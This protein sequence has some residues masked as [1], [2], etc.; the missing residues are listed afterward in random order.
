MTA[1]PVLILLKQNV[2]EFL[3]FANVLSNIKILQKHSVNKFLNLVFTFEVS[4]KQ[5]FMKKIFERNKEKGSS[6]H[7]KTNKIISILTSLGQRI[8]SV[9]L[10]SNCLLKYLN[11]IT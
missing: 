5:K 2:G 6:K 4:G 10:N 3:A 1:A 9:L 11:Y 7:I 8:I